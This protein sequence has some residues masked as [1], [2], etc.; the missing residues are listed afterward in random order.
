MRTDILKLRTSAS[1]LAALEA[2]CEG[3]SGSTDFNKAEIKNLLMDHRKA[4]DLLDRLH[5]EMEE[6]E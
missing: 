3:R 1:T 5:V 6:P 2:K 4:I